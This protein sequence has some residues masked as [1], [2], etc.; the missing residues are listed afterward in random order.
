MFSIHVNLGYEIPGP[1]KHI[2][3]I[4]SQKLYEIILADL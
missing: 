2:A 3:A 4:N 1:K